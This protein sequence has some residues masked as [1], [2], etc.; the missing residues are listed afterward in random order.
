MSIITFENESSR[1]EKIDKHWIQL[2]VGLVRYQGSAL[3]SAHLLFTQIDPLVKSWLQL[4][5]VKVGFLHAQA[6]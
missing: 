4:R 1:S 6:S 2:N 5:R 3:P